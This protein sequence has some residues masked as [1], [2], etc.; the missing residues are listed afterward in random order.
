MQ[1]KKITPLQV[2][3]IATI[4]LFLLPIQAS[5]DFKIDIALVVLGYIAIFLIARFLHVSKSELGVESKQL[6][7]GILPAFIFALIIFVVLGTA[8]LIQSDLF[9]DSRYDQPLTEM[10]IYALIA[11]I[12]NRPFRRTF[13]SRINSWI[14]SKT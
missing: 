4:L 9:K 6:K 1:M 7:A 8:F 13:V 2:L 5:L 11:T 3:A 10:L 14:F 12:K